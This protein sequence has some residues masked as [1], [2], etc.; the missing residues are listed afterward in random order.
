MKAAFPL[1]LLAGCAVL[2]VSPRRMGTLEERVATLEKRLDTLEQAAPAFSMG[3]GCTPYGGPGLWACPAVS[4]ASAPVASVG[5]AVP[6]EAATKTLLGAR[7]ASG[8]MAL[9]SGNPVVTGT[10]ITSTWANNTLSDI[11]T[12]LTDSLSRSN[13]GAMLAPLTGYVGTV[14]L[15]GYTFSGDTNTGLYWVVADDFAAAVGGTKVQEWRTDGVT[16]TPGITVT[17]SQSNTAAGVFTGNGTASGLTTTGGGTNGA[18]VTATGGATNG[19]GVSGTGAGTGNGGTFTG[20]ATGNGIAATGT[21][22]GSGAEITG[23][24]TGIGLHVT[25]GATSNNAFK[26]D[27]GNTVSPP[28]RF[29]TG[30]APSGAAIVGDM[31]MTTAGV[32]KVCVTAGTPCASFVSVGSQP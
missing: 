20:G 22:T 7:N 23:G 2:P 24:T 17:Q 29:G 26:L 28:F 18:G 13:K 21:S 25:G 19:V 9:V 6:Y 1:L 5:M 30:A 31:Y 32:L 15:P 10:T 12:E 16:F 14:S 27:I 3:E 11:A 4:E 8:T